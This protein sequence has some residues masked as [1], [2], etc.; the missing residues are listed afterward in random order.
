[1]RGQI[2]LGRVFNVDIALHYS[3]FVIATL[4]TMSLAGHLYVVNHSWPASVIWTTAVAT[5]LAFFVALVVHELSHAL[6]G[7]AYG[8]PVPAITL[9]ALGGLAHVARE[10]SEPRIEFWMGIAGPITSALIGG[11]GLLLAAALGWTHDATLTSPGMVMLVWFGYVNLGLAAFNMVPAF[12]LDGG[13]VLRAIVW[14]I[15]NDRRRAT[16]IAA[17]IGQF[18]AV[19]FIAFGFLAFLRGAGIGALWLAFI[20]FFLADAA[21]ASVA[22]LE[23][24]ERLRGVR[25]GDIMA[26]ECTVVEPGTSLADMAQQTFR[27]GQRCFLVAI[28]DEV[29]GLVT[30]REMNEVTRERWAAT[31]AREVMRAADRLHHVDVNTPAAEALDVIARENVN[32]LPVLEQ[33]HLRGIISRDRILNLLAA[34]SELS[35]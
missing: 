8:V 23:I 27:T 22:E 12:P 35:A 4:L 33:G 28:R 11:A 29:I 2:E 19:M 7:R 13:R 17:T 24:V 21:R 9:F 14:W 16:R 31:S 18:L 20:G 26:R 25:V 5:A 6:V 34:R 10:P 32:Q 3:W 30:P 1:M 15:T